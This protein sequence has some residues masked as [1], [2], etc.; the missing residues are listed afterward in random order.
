MNEFDRSVTETLTA[1]DPT[2]T[3][4]R[5]DAGGRFT[6]YAYGDREAVRVEGAD[7]LSLAGI[8][9]LAADLVD[10]VDHAENYQLT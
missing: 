10:A 6:V 9:Q 8:R 2:L 5:E 3:I 7:T 4:K 1:A